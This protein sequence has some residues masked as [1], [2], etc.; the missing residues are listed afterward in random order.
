MPQLNGLQKAQRIK[1]AKTHKR[2]IL[3]SILILV[4]LSVIFLVKFS[5]SCAKL[6]FYISKNFNSGLANI[7]SLFNFSVFEKSIILCILAFLVYS[8]CTV[9]NLIFK[10]KGKNEILNYFTNIFTAVSALFFI[11]IV[12]WGANYFSCFS[13]LDEIVSPRHVITAEKLYETAELLLE[14]ANKYS[15]SV[16]RSKNGRLLFSDFSVMSE[17]FP[18]VYKRL[19]EDYTILSTK[20][21][22][23]P[24]LV[25]AYMAMSYLG[26]SGIYSPFTAETNINIDIPTVSLPFTICHETAHRL[27]IVHEDEANFVSFLAGINSDD[28]EFMYSAYFMAYMCVCRELYIIAPYMLKNLYAKENSLLSYDILVYNISINKYETVIKDIGTSINNTYIKAF[29]DSDGVLTYNQMADL[30][31]SYYFP[32]DAFFS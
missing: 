12:L 29:G 21:Y 5:Y 14:N 26:I 17:R 15:A 9:F 25:S 18:D 27:G 1:K 24:K 20:Q 28:P 11:F 32:S 10:R 13:P 30:I 31:V 3:S 16:Q 19:S 23:R 4:S 8:L 2:L 7:M 6:F 22:A